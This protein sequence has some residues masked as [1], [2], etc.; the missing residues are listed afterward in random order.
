MRAKGKVWILRCEP[1]KLE[2]LRRNHDDN[3]GS[4]YGVK[5][6]MHSLITKYEW[7]NVAR[8]VQQYIKECDVCQ[9]NKARRYKPYSLLLPLEIPLT[10]HRH[11]LIDFI[12]DLPPQVVQLGKGIR[13]LDSI[14]VIIDRFSKYVRYFACSKSI[15]ALELADT[16]WRQ[17]ALKNGALHSIVSDCGSVFTS[18]W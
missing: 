7:T 6:T 15:I 8:N 12:T 16:V 5:K 2:I 9:R 3:V 13:T 14:L 10:P 1:L 18:E 17:I 4:H 11:F